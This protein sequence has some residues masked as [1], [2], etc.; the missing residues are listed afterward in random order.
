ML[1]AISIS[2][3]AWI[4]P[5]YFQ[6]PYVP[7][8]TCFQ[9][10]GSCAV[11]GTSQ[12]VLGS[13]DHGKVGTSQVVTISEKWKNP[14]SGK[15]TWVQAL[16]W[17]PTCSLGLPASGTDL[18]SRKGL[19][20]G[21]SPIPDIGFGCFSQK[22]KKKRRFDTYTVHDSPRFATCFDTYGA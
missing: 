19:Y 2:I 14:S 7:E 1:R 10:A 18:K 9:Q 8:E 16:L 11:E 17:F 5:L 15:G 4:F 6:L 3:P 22:E 21:P 12:V 20:S 13:S